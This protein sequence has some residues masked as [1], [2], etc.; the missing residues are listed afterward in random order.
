[1]RDLPVEALLKRAGHLMSNLLVHSQEG[2]IAFKSIEK[3]TSMIERYTH[4]LEELI[5]RGLDYHDHTILESMAIP[6]P[7]SP[8]V[9]RG[10]RSFRAG[11]FPRIFL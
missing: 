5:I 10:Y 2:K 11:V 3:D 4:A 1:M 7:M 8:K 9:M 6:E